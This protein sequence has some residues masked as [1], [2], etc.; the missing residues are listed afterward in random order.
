MA[1]YGITDGVEDNFPFDIRG[2]E[3]AMRYPLTEEVEVIQTKTAELQKAQDAENSELVTKLSKEVEEYLYSF[4]TPVGHDTPV[5]EALSKENIRAMR[6][7]NTMIRTEL[8]I[9]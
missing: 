4:I 1:H 9:S 2:K 3:Y 5:K 7:F 8:A 6:N